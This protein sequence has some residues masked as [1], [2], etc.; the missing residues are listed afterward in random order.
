MGNRGEGPS[1]VS[2]GGEGSIGFT[3][4]V[5]NTKVFKLHSFTLSLF[6]PKFELYRFNFSSPTPHIFFFPDLD[7]KNW[8]YIPVFG[9]FP[10]SNVPKCANQVK[11]N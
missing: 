6:T 2:H 10:K 4:Y 11:K 3:R 1:V 8:N 9:K 5:E 7:K